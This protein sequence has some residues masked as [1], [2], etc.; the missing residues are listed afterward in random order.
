MIALATLF[1][2]CPLVL[3]AVRQAAT[4]SQAQWAAPEL[5]RAIAVLDGRTGTRISLDQL[6][7]RLAAADVVFLGETHTDEATHRVELAVY[8]GLLALREEGVVLA[9]E[10]FERDVQSRL[11]AYLEGDIDEPTFLAGARPWSNYRPAYRPLIERARAG[12]QPVVASNFPRTLRQRMAMEGAAVLETLEGSEREHAPDE[13][14]PNTPAYWRRVDNAIRGHVGMM[15]SLREEDPER[16][17]SVQTL[18]DNS[19]GDSCARALDRHP[20]RLVL[21]VNGG[22][23]SAY[24]DGTARQLR[25]RAPE[26]KVL[27]VSIVPTMNPAVADLHG[28]PVADYVVYTE[29]RASDVNEGKW[30]VTVERQVKYVLHLPDGASD[31]APVPLLIWLS[32]DGF[33]AQDGMALWKERLG[34][35]TAIAVLEAPY[36]ETEEDLAEGGRWFWPDSF[37]EDIGALE[38]ATERSWGYLLRNFPI[39][40]ERVCLAGEGT[41]ASVVAAVS[42]LSTRVAARAIAF[43]PRRYAKI[44]DFPLPLPELRGDEPVPDKSLMLYVGPADE[45]WWTQELA[46]YAAIGFESAM[47]PVTEDPW[48]RATEEEDAL[49]AGLGLEPREPLAGERAHVLVEEGSVR[50]LH[51]ARLRALRYA[52]DAR[53][54]VAVLEAPADAGGSRAIPLAVRAEDYASGAADLPRCPGPFG[55]TTVVCVT[56]ATPPAEVEAWLDFEATDPLNAKSR[57]H[58]LRVALPSGDRALAKVLEKLVAE[59]RTNVL[60]LPA[61]FCADGATMRAL[62]RSARGFEDGMTLQWSPGLGGGGE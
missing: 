39:D 45:A 9:L 30:A 21:H 51:W 24:W 37:T 19:M 38:S 18:W 17:S 54:P 57:F 1:T 44:K 15:A 10:M 7:E 13:I 50:A 14:R 47:R 33:T 27:T 23:H 46:E 53:A 32:D 26:A 52:A 20:G 40:P 34:A 60:I 6:L 48:Q 12:G 2:A 3:P 5:E 59:G 43:E 36:R 16:L 41:G 56:E 49:R 58:R 42:L 62:K 35:E 31:E 22:F 11:D 55:G 28:A 29:A 4:T 25:L 61:A 8:E